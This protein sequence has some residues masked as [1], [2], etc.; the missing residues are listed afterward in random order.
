MPDLSLTSAYQFTLPEE[1]I[2]KQPLAARDSSRLL[3][4]DRRSGMRQHRMFRELPELLR[5]GDLLVLNESKVVPARLLGFR[6]RTQ[7]RWEGLYLGLSA[8]GHWRIIGQTRG[9]LQPGE[10]VFVRRSQSGGDPTNSTSMLRLTLL[11]RED[12][13]VW[14]ATVDSNRSVS[15]LLEEFG[16]MPLP[17]Y[18]GRKV[19]DEADRVRY[20]T[21]YAREAGSVAAPTAGLHFTTEL[22]QACQNRGVEVAWVTLHVGMGTFR[23]VETARLDEHTMHKE[24][25][26][27]PE[28]TAAAIDRCRQRGG[29]VVAVG[30]TTVRTLESAALCRDG[31]LAAWEGET[32][33]FI[34]PGFE[35]RVIDAML[36][37]FHLPGST[38][39]VLVAAFAGYDST[40]NAYQDAINS[41]YRF[42]SYGDAML[43]GD[44]GSPS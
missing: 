13:G 29:R 44:V 21:V 9:K 25:C 22:L 38:L 20:Q 28:A 31:R 37:N 43:I 10:D 36:T 7:G 32:A 23:P 16:T 41:R 35:F 8:D 27:L 14:R 34:R 12:H 24:W 30:T 4:L 26:S 39:L 33:L 5:P 17:P 19:A 1:L 15:D 40:L 2:A 11:E 42:Y 3:V 6:A 18:I